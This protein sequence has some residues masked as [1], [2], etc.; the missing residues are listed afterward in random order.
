MLDFSGT[1]QQELHQLIC[2]GCETCWDIDPA[3]M[4]FKC[5]QCRK[6]I[7]LLPERGMQVNLA[8]GIMAGG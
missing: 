3:W 6:E 4:T 1:D 8:E 7:E 2:P 5:G